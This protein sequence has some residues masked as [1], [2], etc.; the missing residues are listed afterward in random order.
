MKIDGDDRHPLGPFLDERIAAGGNIATLNVSTPRFWI[1]VVAMTALGAIIIWAAL[2]GGASILG[3]L[4]AA[5]GLFLIYTAAR[6]AITGRH[7][8]ILTGETLTDTMGRQLCT[9]AQVARVDRSILAFRP[10]NGFVIYL[11]TGAPTAWHPGLWWRF[12]QRIGVGGLTPAGQG[13]AMADLLAVLVQ[14]L[15][16]SEKSDA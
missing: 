4:L 2:S 1:S 5:V 3:T 8:L 14:D 13:R 16:K 7:G 11:K 9:V 15:E 12:G 10:S 6:I